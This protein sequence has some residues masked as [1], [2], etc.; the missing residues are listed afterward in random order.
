MHI[1][2]GLHRAGSKIRT[3]HLAEILASQER[4]Q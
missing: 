3:L 1:Y 2:G 4:A